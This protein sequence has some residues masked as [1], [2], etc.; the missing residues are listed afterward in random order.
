MQSAKQPNSQYRPGFLNSCRSRG[1][2]ARMSSTHASSSAFVYRE[3]NPKPMSSPVTGQ[4][5]E[6]CGLRSSASQKVNIAAIQKKSDNASVVIRNA[7]TLKIGVT[8]SA[9]TAHKP[10]VSLNN[11]FAK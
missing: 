4:Y 1:A 10:A 6:N 9:T 7:P 8:L 2:N 11:L 3:R 5:Q